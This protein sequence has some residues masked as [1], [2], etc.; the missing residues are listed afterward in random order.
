MKPVRFLDEARTEFLEQ[1]VFYEEQQK[2]LGNRF[3]AAVETAVRLAASRPELGSPW[4]L[5]TRR[6]FLNGFPFAVVYR[7][8]PTELVIFAIAH[9][10]RHPRYWRRRD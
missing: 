7:V 3:R 1:I 10:R 8:E 6:L 9:F 5:R 2:G 4:Q